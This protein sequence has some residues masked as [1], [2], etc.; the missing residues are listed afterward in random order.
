MIFS[1]QT[2][3]PDYFQIYFSLFC[4]RF[5]SWIIPIELVLNTH[6]IWV[7]VFQT[8]DFYFII[9]LVYIHKFILTLNKYIILIKFVEDNTFKMK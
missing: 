9:I 1:I 6:V 5:S 7:H 4:I 3:K 2:D 8:R